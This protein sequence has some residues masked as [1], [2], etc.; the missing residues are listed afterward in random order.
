MYRM[1]IIAE[2]FGAGHLCICPWLTIPWLGHPQSGPCMCSPTWFLIYTLPS[3]SDPPWGRKQLC[4]TGQGAPWGIW[5][6]GSIMGRLGGTG[7]KLEVSMP[8][9]PQLHPRGTWSKLHQQC[10]NALWD[11]TRRTLLFTCTVRGWNKLW[12]GLDGVHKALW[13]VGGD[14]PGWWCAGCHGEMGDWGSGARTQWATLV[15]L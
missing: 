6:T 14:G 8:P 12:R 3:H 9:N 7:D 11:I 10:N 1:G 13:G 2:D 5:A 15:S 4:P